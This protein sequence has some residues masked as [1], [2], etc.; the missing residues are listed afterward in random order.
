MIT[1]NNKNVA[2]IS[3]DNKNVIRVQDANTLEIMWQ[4]TSPTP[5]ANEYFYI[6][7]TYN[8]TNTVTLDTYS[9]GTVSPTQYAST[10]E[11]SKD[12]ITWTTLQLTHN[13]SN[14]ISL[15][16][17]ERVYFR[18]DSEKFNYSEYNT[19]TTTYFRTK[20]TA[21]QS[22]IVGG[23]LNS[24]LDYTNMSTVQT[25]QGCFTQLFYGN[26]KITSAANLIFPNNTSTLCYYYMFYDCT[27]LITPP[28]TLSSTTMSLYSCLFMF[29]RCTSLTSTPTLPATTLATSCYAG[30]FRNCTS[31]VSV[32][33]NLL[34]TTTLAESCYSQMFYDCT[35]LTTSPTLPATTLAEGCYQQMFGNCSSL[36]TSPTLPATTLATDCYRSMFYNCSSL[37]SVTSYAN[38]ITATDCLRVWL[39]G[40]AA[41]GTFHNLGSATYSSGAGG[42]PSGWTEVH[43]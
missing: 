24:L 43:S 33:S 12:K 39:Y 21:N 34:Q 14:T 5:P 13:T 18:N 30:M 1:I 6:E 31:L 25:S 28:T 19:G 26:H 23:N 17:G 10:I 32:P 35:S 40:V 27:S 8:G 3:I 36:T 22:H 16:S 4:K 15:S 29:N 20:F 42:I 7:N 37:N 38:D 11:Y 2:D 9:Q 41:T